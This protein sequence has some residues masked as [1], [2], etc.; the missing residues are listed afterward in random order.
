M[1]RQRGGAVRKAGE[2]AGVGV[3]PRGEGG[4]VSELN[5][6]G[7]QEKNTGTGR[8]ATQDLPRV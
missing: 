6:K 7:S 3:C 8:G 1:G 4:W 2:A 5:I